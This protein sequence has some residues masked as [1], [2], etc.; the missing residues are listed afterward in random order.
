MGKNRIS[1]R[2]AEAQ[3]RYVY[4]FAREG[5]L[6][7][8]GVTRNARRRLS[9]IQCA[10]P[11]KLTIE[12][13]ERPATMSAFGVEAAAMRLLDPWR[14]SGEWFR[15]PVGLA[16]IAV[17]AAQDDGPR[18]QQFFSL[19]AGIDAFERVFEQAQR[20][21]HVH[22]RSPRRAEF[23]AASDRAEAAFIEAFDRRSE[24]FPDLWAQVSEYFAWKIGRGG[25]AA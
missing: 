8:I 17:A 15:C 20:M 24:A 6:V 22:R 7:K 12:H 1:P 13:I 18:Y 11:E 14:V 19:C 4:I 25:E 5:G 10:T 21:L 3:A 16:R 9:G 23:Q 2:R